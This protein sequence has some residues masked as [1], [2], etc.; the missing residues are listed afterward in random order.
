MKPARDL[1]RALATLHLAPM[2]LAPMILASMILAPMILILFLSL[3]G[4]GSCEK[5][6]PCVDQSKPALV[7]CQ[8]DHDKLRTEVIDLKRKLAKALV[9][10]ESI[11]VDPEVLTV[12]G[13]Y[14]LPKLKE[15]NLSKDQVIS[16]VQTNK[17]V[18]KAC[19]ERAMKKNPSL[20]R[21]K[22]TVTLAFKVLPSGSPSGIRVTP[23]YDSHMIDCMRKAIRRWRFP[24]FSGQAVGVETPLHLTP[25]HR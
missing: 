23:N 7:R 2:I 12:N 3:P 17:K 13:E 4:C 8:A 1:I 6:K 19:Y 15:G 22:V 21:Q 11:K 24:S 25:K 18:L 20:R 10:P 9:S 16:T 5:D 14:L